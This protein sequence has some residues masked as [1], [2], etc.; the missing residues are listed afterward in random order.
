[1]NLSKRQKIL[2]G[3]FLIGLAG[4]VAD[5]TILRPQGGPQ[6]ASAEFSAPA[7]KAARHPGSTPGDENL[8]TRAPLAERLNNLLPDRENGSAELRDPFSLPVSWPGSGAANKEKIPDAAATFARTHQLK[9]VVVQG[10]DVSA[11]IDDG[12]L[13]PGQTIDGFQLVSVD[14][15]SAVFEREGKQVVL[16]LVVK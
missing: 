1:M 8:P 4:L 5:R 2:L 6:A 16:E 13:V 10:D 7:P 9:A 14:Y 11:R 3:V 12:F 15:H